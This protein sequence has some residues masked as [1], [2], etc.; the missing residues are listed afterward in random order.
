MSINFWSE[1]CTKNGAGVW[2]LMRF[3]VGLAV[4]QIMQ[5]K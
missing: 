5:H 3:A 4:L 1:I 2:C